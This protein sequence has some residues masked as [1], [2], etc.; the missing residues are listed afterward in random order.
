MTG[1]GLPLCHG[2]AIISNDWQEHKLASVF[3][4]WYT[5]LFPASA[6][7]S[8]FVIVRKEKNPQRSLQPAV[9]REKQDIISQF[10]TVIIPFTTPVYFSARCKCILLWPE[11]QR[12]MFV[13]G[14]AEH[15]L[16]F[17]KRQLKKKT[18]THTCTVDVKC[19]PPHSSPIIN[20]SPASTFELIMV[21]QWPI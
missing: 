12:F 13:V 8:V 1:P 18:H 2:G 11:H 17:K 5:F 14:T 21:H 7:V 3:I 16:S 15:Q 20:I 6:K 19:L 9:L 10:S 4:V